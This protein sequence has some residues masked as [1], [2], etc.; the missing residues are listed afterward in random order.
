MKIELTE[1]E[2][3]Y[4]FEK[5]KGGI[6]MIELTQQILS[7]KLQ[8]TIKQFFDDIDYA[9]KNEGAL[10]EYLAN[11]LKWK[12]DTQSPSKSPIDVACAKKVKKLMDKEKRRKVY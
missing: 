12:Y 4:I 6:L 5:G 3:S 7:K 1:D 2:K 10:D 8:K 9:I 11:D